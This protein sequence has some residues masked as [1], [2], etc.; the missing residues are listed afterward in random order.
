M[1][2]LQFMEFLLSLMHRVNKDQ[3]SCTAHNRGSKANQNISGKTEKDKGK[4]KS[5]IVKIGQKSNFSCRTI[6]SAVN[7]NIGIISFVWRS[8]NLHAAN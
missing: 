4:S 2:R 5:V 1:Q 7:E 8:Q 3:Q 6:S